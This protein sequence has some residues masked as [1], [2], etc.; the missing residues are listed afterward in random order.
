MRKPMIPAPVL[1]PASALVWW[2]IGY[3]PWLAGGLRDEAGR[4]YVDSIA[5]DGL[6]IPLLLPHLSLLVLG[7]VVGGACAGLLT[8]LSNGR[9][10]TTLA[11][12]FAGLACAVLVAGIQSANAVRDAVGSG[13]EADGSVVSA[14]LATA[15]GA[16]L[17]GW[18]FGAG[19]YFGRVPF[20]IAVAGLGGALPAWIGSIIFAVSSGMRSE[21]EARVMFYAGA[22]LLALGLVVI[23]VRPYARL[24]AWPAAIALAWIVTP[25]LTATGYLGGTLRP[26]AT[27]SDRLGPAWDIFTLAAQP[28]NTPEM[29]TVPFVVAIG[30]AAA[31]AVRLAMR[32]KV[33]DRAETIEAGDHSPVE[34]SSN[35]RTTSM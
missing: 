35:S 7:G 10:V 26:P 12:S 27:L 34:P 18:L 3:L 29:W 5:S 9:A 15:A 24:L 31:I 22:A 28:A 19:A 16:S 6:T 23:G 1:A 14:L 17:L 4:V 33:S 30:L 32:S 25:A 13:Y 21:F 2:V 20:G 11:A 8:M